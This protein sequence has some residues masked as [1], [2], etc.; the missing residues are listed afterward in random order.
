MRLPIL[1]LLALMAL[2]LGLR[3]DIEVP[4]SVAFGFGQSLAD[5]L[6]LLKSGPESATPQTWH[7]YARDPFRAGEQVRLLVT[8]E[9]GK[10]GAQADGEATSLRK[11]PSRSID[12][13]RVKVRTAEAR[14][15]AQKAAALAQA[16]FDKVD[17][18][19]ATNAETAVPEWGMALIDAED[20][21]VG[22]CIVS[23]ETGA[24]LFQNWTPQDKES[25][26]KAG[27]QDEGER[28]AVAVKKGVRRAWDWTENAGKKTGSFFRELF[29]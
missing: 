22:F 3:A 2:P 17:Y 18:Q 5:N 4:R 6:L 8:R 1:P 13:S 23:A 29:R 9:N 19:L 25:G 27:P 24:L 14:Q 11:V 7:A 28:A 21:E 12:F 26:L 10:W 15:V 20:N 16:D